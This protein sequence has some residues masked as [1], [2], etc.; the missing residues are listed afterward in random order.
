MLLGLL[1]PMPGMA[2]AAPGMGMM[3]PGHPMFPMG[4][5][6]FRWSPASPVVQQTHSHTLIPATNNP[7]AAAA[8]H[9]A[10]VTAVQNGQLLHLTMPLIYQWKK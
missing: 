10:T 8:A 4:L 6:R 9:A 2:M 5:P 7:A 1:A 3:F